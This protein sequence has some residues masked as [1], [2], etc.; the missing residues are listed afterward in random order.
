M[1]LRRCKPSGDLKIEKQLVRHNT[2]NA[3][4][5]DKDSFSPL[6]IAALESSIQLFQELIKWCPDSGE[7]VD[8]KRRNV[9]HFAVMSEDFK[10]IK[11]A[12]KQQELEE[13]VNKA[14]DDGNNP[15]HLAATIG[16]LI[17]FQIEE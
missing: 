3:Y 1:L 16:N 9:F 11:F 17:F 7:L 4:K 8:K 15:F 10:K 6:H 14:D 5:L 2:S 13:L 12:L